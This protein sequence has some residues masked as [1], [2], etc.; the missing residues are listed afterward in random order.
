MKRGVMGGCGADW[1]D[2]LNA[3]RAPFWERGEHVPRPRVEQGGGSR[4]EARP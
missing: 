1:S 3:L 4:A 2:P